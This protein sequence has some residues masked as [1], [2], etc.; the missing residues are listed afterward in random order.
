[1][2]AHLSD[3]L[4]EAQQCLA[5]GLFS[6]AELVEHHAFQVVHEA[7]QAVLQH[8]TNLAVRN[9]LGS[10][11]SARG[12]RIFL[13]ET[14]FGHLLESIG[15]ELLPLFWLLGSHWPY[16]MGIFMWHT[17]VLSALVLVATATW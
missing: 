14:G 16:I 13:D 9:G 11:D 5:N 12:F 7:H 2:L 15:G 17:L 1:M 4:L 3:L 8:V 6:V 10:S